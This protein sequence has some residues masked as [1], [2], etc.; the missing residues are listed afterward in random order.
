MRTVTY[1]GACSLDMFLAGPDGALDWLRY[2]PDVQRV[3]AAYWATIDTVLVGRK[4]WE[5]AARGAGGWTSGQGIVTYLFSRTMREAPAGVHLVAEDAGGFVR[6][7]KRRSGKGICLMGG[8]ELAHSLF[9]A[10]VIDEVGLNVHPVLLGA[11]VPVFHDLGR[12][13]ALTL[14]ESR[15]LMAGCVLL[16]YRVKRGRR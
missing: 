14:K 1:G 12:R 10:E 11:G 3:M 15:V 2:S 5:V 6:R 7:L 9:D 8:A 16:T 13:V 4:T